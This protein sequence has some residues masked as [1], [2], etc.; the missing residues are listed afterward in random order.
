MPLTCTDESARGAAVNSDGDAREF[1][2]LGVGVHKRWCRGTAAVNAD[3]DAVEINASAVGVQ[4]R[5]R[6]GRRL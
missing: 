6:R 5:G 4:K 3:A 1:D 2:A